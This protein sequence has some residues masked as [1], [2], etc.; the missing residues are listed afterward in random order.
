[1]TPPKICKWIVEHHGCCRPV[2]LGLSVSCKGYWHC[3]NEN[4]ACPLAEGEFCCN[5]FD[6]SKQAA[7]AWLEAHKED[8]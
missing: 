1:M 6:S 2:S 3:V 8:V 5:N 7:Q 4:T